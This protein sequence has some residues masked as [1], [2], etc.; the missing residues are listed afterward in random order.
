MN[1]TAT[2]RA[3][4]DPNKKECVSLI[5]KRL[6]ITHSEAINIFYSLIEE[7]RGFPFSIKLPDSQDIVDLAPKVRP[8]VI[9]HL[10]SSIKKNRRLGE[11]LAK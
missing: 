6:G 5:L 3:L 4:M 1:R 10:K 8:D 7:Y 2:V 9:Q 11:L